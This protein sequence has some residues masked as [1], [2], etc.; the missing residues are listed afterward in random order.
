MFV[1]DGMK[2]FS[3][4]DEFSEYVVKSP[5]DRD[6]RK[7]VF[8]ALVQILFSELTPNTP[9]STAGVSAAT[10]PPNDAEVSQPISNRPVSSPS[11]SS[12]S[13]PDT[14]PSTSGPSTHMPFTFDPGVV[15]PLNPDPWPF[16]TANTRVDLSSSL[17]LAPRLLTTI[18]VTL[19]MVLALTE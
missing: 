17:A 11:K 18:C 15:Q 1:D 4:V 14:Q 9:S 19:V 8:K 5:S 3:F 2:D 16:L 7:S 10:I 13:K 6:L 12:L